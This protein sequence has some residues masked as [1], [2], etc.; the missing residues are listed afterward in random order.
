M[1]VENF[2]FTSA[3][4]LGSCVTIALSC[5]HFCLFISVAFAGVRASGGAMRL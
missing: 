2:M 5:L 1:L 4:T 3:E